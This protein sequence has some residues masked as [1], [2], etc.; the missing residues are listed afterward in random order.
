MMIQLCGLLNIL[1]GDLLDRWTPSLATLVMNYSIGP[2]PAQLL[3]CIAAGLL[4]VL[5][6][7][8]LLIEP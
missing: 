8:L 1:I 2:L 4:S 7:R 5:L 3:L 6:R